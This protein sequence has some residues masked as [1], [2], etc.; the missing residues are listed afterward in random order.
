[1]LLAGGI[2]ITALLPMADALRR[3]GADYSVV[4]VGRSREAMAYLERIE[5]EHGDRLAVRVSSEGARVDPG[6]VVAS[7]AE[8]GHRDLAELYVCGPHPLLADVRRAW[9]AADLP[10]ANLRFETF[11]GGRP[12]P[13]FVARVRDSGAE[14]TVG[15]EETL[16]DALV[17]TGVPLMFD[18]LKGECGLCVLTVEDVDGD[19]DH[20][21]VFLSPAE[22]SSGR[23]ICACVSRV[24]PRPGTDRAV[25]TLST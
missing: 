18:C 21:D 14:T 24:V 11:G 22:R 20:R 4:Y 16:L 13:S 8:G 1:M 10:T 23:A 5:V 25:V 6:Q 2:G 15:T 7:L 3:A 12:G 9:L 17:R 19:I